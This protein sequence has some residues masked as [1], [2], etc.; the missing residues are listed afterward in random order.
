MDGK[1]IWISGS[2]SR[3]CPDDKLQPAIQFVE[4]F[5]EEVLRQGGGIVVLAG[6]EESTKNE[7]GTPSIFDWVALREV[8]RYA[9]STI[10]PPRCYAF[11][12]MSDEGQESKIDKINLKLLRNLE[13]RGVIEPYYI[14]RELFTG[15]AYRE[16]MAGISDAM[17]ALGGGKGTYSA[18]LLM[19]DSDK[20]V[21]PIDLHLGS[22]VE[23]GEGAVALYRKMMSD[24]VGFFPRTHSDARS[25]IGL[26]SLNRGVNKVEAVAQT[27]AEIL[28]K[29][30]DTTTTLDRP[31]KVKAR[32]AKVKQF[33]TGLPVV[34]AAI[35]I[36]EFLRG[37]LPFMH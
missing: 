30:L 3:S 32:W 34:A 17:L 10:K 2:A 23:D 20:P 22:I 25:R 12:V 14:R 18:G 8:E 1:Y 24:P 7:Q 19:I 15:G 26:L 16:K 36:V 33:L 9:E 35:K 13:Q 6:G 29:E 31:I 4:S 27:A 5:T 21:L 11:I 37:A 28:R